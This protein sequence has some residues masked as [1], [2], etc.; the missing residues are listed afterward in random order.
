M[1]EARTQPEKPI[2]REAFF[3]LLGLAM[4]AGMVVLGEENVS[5]AIAASEG[6]GSSDGARTKKSGKKPVCAALVLVDAGASANTKKKFADSCAYYG[7]E[8]RL[9]KAD[10]L[11]HAVGR[12]GRMS[13]AVTPGA[14]CEK[15]RHLA[16]EEIAPDA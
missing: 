11:G 12:P 3:S 7:V 14:L 10:R 13:A 9:T 1:S 2:E 4:R 6:K 8:M 5:R 16:Q 15:L